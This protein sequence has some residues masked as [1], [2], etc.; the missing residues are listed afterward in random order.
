[1]ALSPQV[2]ALPFINKVTVNQQAFGDKVISIAE[3]L[4]TL[5]EYLMIVMNNESGLN[6]SIK[7]PTS[8]A[9][10]LIQFME[11]TA[12]GLGTTTA[13]L[14]AMTNVDQLD[15]VYKYLKV[16][17]SKFY[18]VS[19][20]YLAVFFP[21]ALYE[22]D[23]WNFPLWAV[24]ANKIFDVNKDGILTKKEFKN[25]VN[26]KYASYIPTQKVEDFKKKRLIVNALKVIGFILFLGLAFYGIYYY[27]YR[28][29]DKK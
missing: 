12:K 14:A 24:R 22:S 28:R 8:T 1:M 20:V 4:D 10:G 3:K 25:Y 19:D 23:D 27:F 15:Y 5:P 21:Q 26:V 9:T 29:K 2:A 18:E 16:Y 6:S 17:Q 7:N 13:A 11:P